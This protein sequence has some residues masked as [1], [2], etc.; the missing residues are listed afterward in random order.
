LERRR[1]AAG[2]G[3]AIIVLLFVLRFV[4]AVI[5]LLG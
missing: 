2:F 1:L 3:I 4:E 5:S